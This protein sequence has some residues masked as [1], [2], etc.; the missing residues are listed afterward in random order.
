MRIVFFG[1]LSVILLLSWVGVGL[2]LDDNNCLR[3]GSRGVANIG[4]SFLEVFKSTEETFVQ[5]GPVA[6]GT[7]GL[8]K[9][10]AK[11]LLRFG[12][13]I[14]EGVTFLIPPYD[15]VLKDPEFFFSRDKDEQYAITHP[16]KGMVPGAPEK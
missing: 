14:Y 10:F 7:Y 3:K 1:F 6:A 12:V 8:A 4:T 16:T 9:G 15:P 13:G 11:G 5:D 2:A